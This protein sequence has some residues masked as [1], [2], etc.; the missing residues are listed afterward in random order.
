MIRNRFSPV[1]K[2]KLILF[3]L[4]CLNLFIAK[5]QNYC[6]TTARGRTTGPVRN[7]FPFPSPAANRLG[8][9]ET[10]YV[11][12]FYF[13]LFAMIADGIDCAHVSFLLRGAQKNAP[14]FLIVMQRNFYKLRCILHLI[15]T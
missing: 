12:S 3:I 10:Y 2:M 13:D 9:D 8:N 7:L 4:V 15:Y 14:Q 6:F 5:L 11:K 1:G